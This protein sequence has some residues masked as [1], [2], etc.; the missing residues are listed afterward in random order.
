MLQFIL[1]DTEIKA[2]IPPGLP[3]LDFV[4]Y[5]QHLTGTKIG[6]RE[7][8]CGACTMLVGDIIDGK[9]IYQSATSCLMASG[10]A[11]G[12]HIVTIE[13]LNLEALNVIQ[14][15]FAQEGASQCGFCTPG[16][17][18]S[19]AGY[20][21]SGKESNQ[22]NAREYINGNICRCTGYKSIER[23]AERLNEVL[24][25]N[26]TKHP[27]EFAIEAGIIPA[28]FADI[29]QK[30]D[31]IKSNLP[32]LPVNPGA[33]MLGGGTDL[34][35]QQHEGMVEADISFMWTKENLDSITVT[36]NRMTIG[37]AITVTSLA[38]HPVFQKAF[39][40]WSSYIELVSSTPIR[41]MATI[42]GNFTNASPIGDFTIFFL[43]LD[44]GL[45]LHGTN[46]MREI[47]LRSFYKGYKQLEKKAD[48]HIESI[49]FDLPSATTKFNFEKV[50]KRTWLDIASVNSAICINMDGDTIASASISAGG[51]GPIP[52]FLPKASAVLEGKS[53]T[54]A[55][56]ET[57]IDTAQQEI[58]PISDARG[59]S[60]YKRLL[61][62]QLIRAHAMKLFPEIS[63]EKLLHAS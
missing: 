40:H 30:L 62:S 43:A 10:Q 28:Y 8:D 22:D 13:G 45:Q 12:K 27:V 29:K 4:R 21:I 32:L 53:F 61:L 19:L 3:L 24:Q 38:S 25:S 17:I 7:G 46:G 41:N 47:S 56:L 48:E 39:P 5:H 57:C 50:S 59:T 60:D 14:E 15:A 63:V 37:G 58:S 23:A 44:A 49:S 55:L 35:V 1:N 51:V 31:V 6:C 26:S 11:H 2:A 54:P 42:A 18:V 34:Y 20:A 9:L 16:F 52:M 36:G 33:K